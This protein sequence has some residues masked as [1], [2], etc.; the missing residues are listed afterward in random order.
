MSLHN[1]I[2]TDFGPRV[3]VAVLDPDTHHVVGYHLIKPE[4]WASLGAPTPAVSDPAR[5]DTQRLEAL[6]RE[7]F[8]TEAAQLEWLQGIEPAF[9]TTPAALIADDPMLGVAR[10]IDHLKDRL[11]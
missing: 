10:I 1:I 11:T 7:A 6:L 2:D 9:G 5:E 8:S 3:K 4:T